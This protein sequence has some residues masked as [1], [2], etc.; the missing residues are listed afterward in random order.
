LRAL[1]AG[2]IA[3]LAAAGVLG[4]FSGG[5]LPGLLVAG[6]TFGGVVVAAGWGLGDDVTRDALRGAATRLRSGLRRL[7][8]RP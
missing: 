1:G 4:W 6:A 3:G 2:G 7:G 5:G 8:G